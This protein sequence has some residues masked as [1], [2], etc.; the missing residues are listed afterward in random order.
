MTLMDT[1][2]LTG[3][4][5]NTE[6]FPGEWWWT[7]TYLDGTER[8]QLYASGWDTDLKRANRAAREAAERMRKEMD[9]G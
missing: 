4:V 5:Y 6:L 2:P 9:N 3:R 8:G 1:E 7:V